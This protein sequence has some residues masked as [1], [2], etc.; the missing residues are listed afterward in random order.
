MPKEEVKPV[1]EVKKE[2]PKR[3]CLRCGKEVKGHKNRR[4]CDNDCKYESDKVRQR[5]YNHRN[6]ER[7]MEN[8]KI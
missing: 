3:V 6:K 2:A 4:Y 5:T 1:P 7:M 8:G